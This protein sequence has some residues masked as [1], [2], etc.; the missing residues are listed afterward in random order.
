MVEGP[1]GGA[2]VEAHTVVFC[3]AGIPNYGAVVLRLADGAWTMAG[4]PVED[5]AV[6]HP[7]ESLGVPNAAEI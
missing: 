7:V 5:R 1:T 4:V 2:E 3:T 6:A